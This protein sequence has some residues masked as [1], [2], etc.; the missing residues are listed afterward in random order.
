[1]VSREGIEPQPA[2]C[3]SR[4]QPT[5]RAAAHVRLSGRDPESMISIERRN[6][7]WCCGVEVE[8]RRIPGSA[9]I[10]AIYEVLVRSSRDLISYRRIGR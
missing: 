9:D 7:D 4:D 6:R 5:V 10:L 3:A 1:M 2:D 8:R